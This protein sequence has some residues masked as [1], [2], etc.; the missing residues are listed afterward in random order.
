MIIRQIKRRSMVKL[1]V[2]LGLNA[3]FLLSGVTLG[4]AEDYPIKPIFLTVGYTPGGA[5]GISAQILAEGLKKYLPRPQPILINYKPGAG[6]AIS[7]DYILKQPADGYNLYWFGMELCGKLAKDAH[8]LPFTLEDFI[9]IGAFLGSPWVLPVKKD[10]PFMKLEDFI[11]Y[12][13]KH[14][15]ELS[16]GCTGIGSSSHVVAEMLQMR[17]GVKL[18]QIPFTGSAPATAALLGGHI[19]TS[20]PTLGSVL[21]HIQPGGGLRLLAVFTRERLLD[22]P[23]VPTCLEQG[24]DLEHSVWYSVAVAKG[25][26]PAILKILQES[27]KKTADDPQVKANISRLGYMPLNWGPEETKK[28]AKEE[29]DLSIEIFKKV[30]LL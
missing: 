9:H 6:T 26:P 11:D 5:A 13:K 25:T 22:L 30:G 19:T 14:P 24:Y 1:F 18:N 2:L 28:K 4:V 15:G 12:A 8:K 17:C 21:T 27:L 7:A 20:F 16:Y 23:N 10:S 29:F 3:L